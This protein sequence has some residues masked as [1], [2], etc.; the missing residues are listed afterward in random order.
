MPAPAASDELDGVVALIAA[1]QQRPDRNIVYVGEQVDGIRAELDDLDP[2]WRTTV[3]VVHDDSGTVVG[4]ALAEWSVES[5]RAWLFGPWV[6]GPD[7]EWARWARALFDAVAAQIPP[8]IADRELS[9]TLA[10]ERLAALAA[11]LGWPP[12]ETNHAYV[13]D[14]AV[15]AAWSPVVDG[16]LRTV[17]PDDLPAIM[18]LHES[19]FPASYFSAPQLLERAAA[20]EHVVVLATLEDGSFAGYAAGRVQPDGEGYIDF[21][22]VEP[23]TRGTGA[24]RRLVVGLTTRLLPATA[25]GRVHLTVQDHRAPAHALYSAL[26]FRLDASFRGY[27]TRP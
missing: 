20:G 21:V 7:V 10:N 24:G 8:A 18:P 25:T 27:R 12:T 9:G 14:A 5:G 4:A 17:V 23:A 13:L 11:E 1:Q 15:A 19:E 2:D 22:A 6:D 3:R 26:G 16:N